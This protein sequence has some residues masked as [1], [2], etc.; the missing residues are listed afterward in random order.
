MSALQLVSP[1]AGRAARLDEVP[2]EAFAQG[3]VGDG[4]A[5]DPTT[6]ELRA[7]CD[8]VIE[9]VHSARH[10]C[11][12]RTATGAQVLLH[13]GV[14][15]V[16]MRGEGFRAL[17]STGQRVRAG[18]PLI[19]FD[20]ELVARRAKSALIAIVLVSEDGYTV[21]E[22]VGGNVQLAV[23]DRLMAISGAGDA[24]DDG[25][26]DIPT[27][28]AVNG[29]A[30]HGAEQRVAL[31]LPHG[32]HARPAAAFARRARQHAGAVAV[33]HGAGT[34]NGKSAVALMA[35]GAR[36][37]DALTIYAAGA[38][39]AETVGALAALVAS[40]ADTSHVDAAP[41]APGTEQQLRGV[42][43]ARGLAVG[44]AVVLADHAAPVVAQDGRGVELEAQALARAL[45]ELRREIETGHTGTSAADE[46]F[47]AHAELLDD[48]ELLSAAHR[49]ISA[50]RSAAWAWTSALR[51][52]AA[53]LRDSG[54]PLL[55]ERT[56][57]LS[58]LERRTVAVLTGAAASRIPEVL[59]H[60]AILVADDLL[61]SDLAA[62]PAGRVAALC[63][64]GGGPTS[65][66][67]VLAAGL[68]IPALVALGRDVAR[69]PP[70][71]PLAVDAIRGELR[72]FPAATTRAVA[73]RAIAANRARRAGEL[74]AAHLG[75]RTTDGVEVAVLA[76][77]G[78][79]ADAGTA[80]ENGAEG[81]GLLRTEFLFL[82]RATAPTEDE[83]T[84]AYQEIA[85]R[86]R[87]WPLVIRIFDAGGDK[88]LP[89]LPVAREDNPALGVRGVRLALRNPAL[90]RSQLRAILRVRPAGVCRI[91]V[92][93]VA[94][95]AE[96]RAVR[97]IVEE[98]RRAL[99]VTEPA[100]VG[101]MIE[102]PAAAL[103]AD[104]L[105]PEVDFFSIG[106]ND[107]TQY[108]LAMDRS[109]PQ[110]AASFDS[111]DPGVL[112]LVACA[113]RG[114]RGRL[115]GA[116]GGVDPF[117]APLFL[118]LGVGTLSAAPAAV[119]AIKALLRTVSLARCI[120]IANQA[121][122]LASGDAVRAL[123]ATTWPQ[124]AAEHSHGA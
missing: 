63:T 27:N 41:F 48:P 102:V 10:A 8:G 83:Q 7:P 123:V 90:L 112:R 57:D 93:M 91:L 67:A 5:I 101:A 46:I 105:A 28:G 1:L 111:L 21:S 107:L 6:N 99:G 37:G 120:E 76:N 45:A 86:L 58:D 15:T 122:D 11:T 72:V 36:R 56:A 40:P 62:L 70:G 23:G 110:L 115:V 64:A 96:L 79:P 59:P 13:I 85:N 18:D 65:H 17:V 25:E 4:I 106:T 89:Y 68:G 24:M 114:A 2:D 60:G 71:A 53:L 50:G 87:G 75:V 38:G 29:A 103:L 84:A 61:P 78:R 32:L 19:A 100:L 119:P 55:A 69:I 81:C 95:V 30:T 22:R 109:N 39:A 104:K 98:E 92:P 113:V 35:L 124:L 16:S 88:P 94:S 3:M 116:C 51:G 47:R 118:G 82:E 77:L 43:A 74:A 34:A 12:V 121:L 26:L 80:I 49:E 42:I 9:F 108:A 54:N 117:A 73:D 33:A 97:A 20:R 44:V 31:G 14:D 66:V 52:Y